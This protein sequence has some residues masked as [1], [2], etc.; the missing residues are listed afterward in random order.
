M[1]LYHSHEVDYSWYGY[2]INGGFLKISAEIPNNDSSIPGEVYA[3]HRFMTNFSPDP[4][5]V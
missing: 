1:E 2:Q 4:E 5:I 3:V